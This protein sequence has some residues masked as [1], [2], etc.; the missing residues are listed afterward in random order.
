MARSLFALLLT[1][2]LTS[3]CSRESGPPRPNV[4]LISVDTLRADHLGSYG[5]Q[6]ETSPF[7]DSLADRGVRFERAYAQASWTL[8]SHVS[9]LSS[10][11]P[12]THQVENQDRSIP[13]SIPLLAELLQ[14]EG[15]ETAAF[16]SW[17][18]L[19]KKFGFG[20]G[21]DHF[22]ALLPHPSMR[23]SSTRHS[24]RA[25]RFVDVVE[26]W[27][28]TPPESPFFL[29][30]HLFDPHLSYVPPLEMARLFE[31]D[32]EKVEGGEY[33]AMR[34]Y[35]RGLH[36]QPTRIGAAEL[37]RARALYQGE[38][39][40]TD[41]QLERLFAI[42]EQKGLLENTLIVFTSDHGEEFDEHGSMEGH[43][44]T[45]YDEVLHIPLMMVLPGDERAGTTV[46]QQVESID[47]APTILD[48]LGITVPR[49]F[50]GRSMRPLFEGGA[51]TD[52]D[53]TAYASIRRFNLKWSVRTP[54][55]KLVFTA[56]T[57]ENRWGVAITP[58]Y[59]LFDLKN[60]PR[61][62]DNIFAPDQLPELV[63][64]LEAFRKQ[65]RPL[66]DVNQPELTPE[67][68]ERL[69]ATGYIR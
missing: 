58:G 51:T 59:E 39:R 66:Q 43:Q 36:S 17:I 49:E 34:P 46:R 5:H 50:E 3:A 14:A 15:Y 9:L 64:R 29:F 63:D 68:R 38:I 65:Q 57:G 13:D 8:P 26:S 25:D 10:T 30:F 41:G 2:L 42:L 1:A 56:D 7:L 53:E 62:Q 11:Y 31:P 47:V 12:H 61:E 55:H 24:T 52:W 32:L 44:W 60:D 18:Y 16:V 69:E 27:L 48:L 23:D 33:A 37:A 28:E 67:E 45:L 20:R 40:F 21:I 4:I 54:R 19:R 6:Q 22:Q 35:I